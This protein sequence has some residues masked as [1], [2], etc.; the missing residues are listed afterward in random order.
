MHDLKCPALNNSIP[1]MILVFDRSAPGDVPHE[2]LSCWLLV[3]APVGAISVC[4]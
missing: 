4:M 2:P 1:P 3:G